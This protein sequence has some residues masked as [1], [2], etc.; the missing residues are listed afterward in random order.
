MIAIIQDK[1]EHLSPLMNEKLRRH[2]AA[3]EALALGRGGV[4]AIAR[5]TGLSRNTIHKGIGELQEQMPQLID[6]IDPGRV[7]RRGGGRRPLVAKDEALFDDLEQL[8]EANTRGDPMSALLWTCKSTRNLAV[9]LRRQG[10]TVSHMTVSRLLDVMGYHLQSN[11]KTHEGGQHEDR[12]AQFQHINR[13]VQAFRRRGQPVISVDAKK[14]ELVGD[15]RQDGREW[16]PQGQPEPVRMHDFRDKDLGIAIPYGVYDLIRNEGW[17]NV[18]IDR[19]T[20]EFASATI[21]HWWKKMGKPVYLKAKELLIMA[22]SGGSNGV[23]SR[24]WKV[25]VQK[26]ADELGLSVTVCH[27]PPGTSKWNKIEHRMFCY[28]T[29]NWRGR[30]LVSQAVIVNLIGGTKTES[31]L[32]IEAELDPSPYKKRIKVTDEELA[33]VNIHKDSFHGEWNYTIRPSKSE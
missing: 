5:A 4:S 23:H 26:L 30:P 21:G 8:L 20:S 27:F 31:G 9:E 33:S 3:C 16:R 32:R 28:I 13:Q 15:F 10:H 29:Q 6:S 17:V 11:R 12:D 18:G 25:S 7:R 1:Y 2:W 24:L 19:N 22:D 14:K